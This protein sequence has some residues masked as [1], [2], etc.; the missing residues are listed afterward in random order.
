MPNPLLPTP[1]KRPLFTISR[2]P[3]DD[4]ILTIRVGQ[5]DDTY[6][7]KNVPWIDPRPTVR[8][9]PKS[10]KP[11]WPVTIAMLEQLSEWATLAIRQEC[12]RNLAR[13]D[14]KADL[15]K[16]LRELVE[17]VEQMPFEP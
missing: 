5:R 1:R 17:A 8:L 6:M 2:A 9:D 16:R 14:D 11:S 12:V 4:E 10:L 15:V 3:H 13:R 7:S